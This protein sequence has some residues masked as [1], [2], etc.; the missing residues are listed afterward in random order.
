MGPRRWCRGMEGGFAFIAMSDCALQWG[1]D[2]GVVEWGIAESAMK[3]GGGGWIAA[4][5]GPR[6]WCRGMAPGSP[7]HERARVVLQWGHDDGVVEWTL[8]SRGLGDGG[9]LQWGHDDGVVEWS[10][11]PRE[12]L[13]GLA[14]LQWGHDDGVVEW[15]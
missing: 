11:G 9:A 10:C 8:P 2:D 14:A 13:Q 3:I 7:D 4:S 15:Q 1:H 5:M 12:R 6:R